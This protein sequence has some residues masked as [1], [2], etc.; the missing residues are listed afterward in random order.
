MMVIWCWPKKKKKNC[1]WWSCLESS[2]W[3]IPY[4]FQQPGAKRLKTNIHPDFSSFTHI[5]G[6]AALTFTSKSTSV[7]A[8]KKKNHT[9]VWLL[10]IS[11]LCLAQNI[12]HALRKPRAFLLD[13]N[14]GSLLMSTQLSD[15]KF[16]LILEFHDPIP[17]PQ[18]PSNP[19]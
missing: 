19:C 15:I 5:L 18:L 2:S 6:T 17:T 12:P 7:K 3:K 13:S 14:K 8:K 11:H 4:I 1:C 16:S 10:S 9:S